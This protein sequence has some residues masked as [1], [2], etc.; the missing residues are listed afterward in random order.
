MHDGVTQMIVG[1]LYE[2]EAARQALFDNPDLAENNLTHAQQLLSEVETEIRRVIYDLHPPVL[3]MMG[4]VVALKRFATTYTTTF[5]IDCQVQ[6]EGRP[7]RLPKETEISIYRILQAAL[8][9]VRSH[10]QASRSQISFDFGANQ[11]LVR[12]EDDG[13]GFDPEVIFG[14]PG[15]HLGLLGMKERAEGIGASLKVNAADG[16]GA[17]ID[18]RLLSPPYLEQEQNSEF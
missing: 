8:N 7:R 1:A 9:N 12:V 10:A 17:R 15:D 4:L 2:T 18:L 3:D 6:V 16:E 14:T 13:V 11:L 5:G